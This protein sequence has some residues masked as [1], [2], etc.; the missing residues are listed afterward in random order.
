MGARAP[1]PDDEAPIVGSFDDAA[2]L[3]IEATNVL[4]E[5]RATA[6]LVT[7]DPDRPHIHE[8]ESE[9]QGRQTGTIGVVYMAER[10]MLEPQTC[11]QLEVRYEPRL[12][13]LGVTLP[14]II[15]V[16]LLE[17]RVERVAT[18]SPVL[19]RHVVQLRWEAELAG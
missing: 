11:L 18:P 2:R 5:I 12:D 10:P 16:D 13:V 4:N 7:P 15:S 14:L 19:Y 1:V 8:W 9:I 3:G 6:R 17:A